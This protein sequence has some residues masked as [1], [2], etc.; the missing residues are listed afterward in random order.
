VF[1]LED[2]SS[3][4]T[5]EKNIQLQPVELNA[6]VRLKN[7][8]FAS[9]SYQLEAVSMIELNKLVQLMHDNPEIKIQINGYTDN[10]GSEADNLTLSQ[11]RSNAVVAYLVSEGIDA[12]RLIAKGYGEAKPVADN[13]TEEGRSINRRT[14]FMVTG[15]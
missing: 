2:K 8:Q 3:D 1:A 11:N 6:S 5:Y 13:V 4:S 14:E 7:I 10:V 12:K 9:K 15:L